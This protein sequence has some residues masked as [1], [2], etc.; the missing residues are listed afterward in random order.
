MSISSILSA[1]IGQRQ[2][3]PTNLADLANKTP[4][5]S[6]DPKVT[7]F[8]VRIA[9]AQGMQVVASPQSFRPGQAFQ[10]AQANKTAQPRFDKDGSFKTPDEKLNLP[11]LNQT[12]ETGAK[13]EDMLKTLAYWE[14]VGMTSRNVSLASSAKE[15]AQGGVEQRSHQRHA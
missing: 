10:L 5:G 14:R 7:P 13:T 3:A 6:V 8:A 1:A 9:T 11:Q 12:Y 4:G 2:A 15:Q